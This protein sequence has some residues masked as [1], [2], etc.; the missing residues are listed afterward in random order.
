MGNG[1]TKY[2]NTNRANNADPQDDKH[3]SV[4]QSSLSTLI[5]VLIGSDNVP[6]RSALISF[7]S[8]GISARINAQP[9]TSNNGN[10]IGFVGGSRSTSSTSVKRVNATNILDSMPSQNPSSLE[11]GVFA[12]GSG[13]TVANNRIAFYSIGE[14]LDLALLDARVTTLINA[15]GAI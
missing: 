8:T 12:T 6:G 1:T 3:L 4:Y 13:G 10:G 15:Y 5:S 14:S 11:I 2:L 7:P 9:T